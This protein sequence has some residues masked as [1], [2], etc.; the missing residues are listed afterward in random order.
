LR[1][2]DDVEHGKYCVVVVV[3]HSRNAGRQWIITAFLTD[4]PRRG[5]I[6]WLKT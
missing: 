3:D 5:D 6:E 4:R 1:W 2:Y